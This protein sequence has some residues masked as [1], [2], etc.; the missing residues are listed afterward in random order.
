MTLSKINLPQRT[1]G[2]LYDRIQQKQYYPEQEARTRTFHEESRFFISLET[3]TWRGQSVLHVVAADKVSF[4]RGVAL[5]MFK[6]IVSGN[7]SFSC[8]ERPTAGRVCCQF[9]YVDVCVCVCMYV[10]MYVC[11]CVSVLVDS[12]LNCRCSDFRTRSLSSSDGTDTIL[13]K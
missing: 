10:C 9:V 8:L 4:K 7:W 6:A 1:G 3:D 2:E 12:H 5:F 11:V 13:H